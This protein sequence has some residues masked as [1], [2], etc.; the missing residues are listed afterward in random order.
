MIYALFAVERVF[1]MNIDF[2]Q[3][4][5]ELGENQKFPTSG[6]KNP[7]DVGNIAKLNKE[8]LVQGK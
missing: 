2:I 6:M 7:C 1:E 5:R 4:V 3:M 8:K